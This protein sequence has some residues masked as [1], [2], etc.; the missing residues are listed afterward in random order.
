MMIRLIV[1]FQLGLLATFTLS[2][3]K[4]A[5]PTAKPA[6]PEQIE[7][8]IDSSEAP[9]TLVHVWATWCDPCREEFPELVKVMHEFPSMGV[10]LISADSPKEIE[11]VQTFLVD[12]NS[13]ADSLITTE[14]N[15]KF[16][17]TLS[18]NW[19]GALPATFFFRNGKCVSEWEGK[20]TF[21]HYKET[22]ENLL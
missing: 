4:P 10:V 13:P 14:L 5:P 9:L 17:E 6:S 22:I 16:I 20:K 15:Q 11:N 1:Y 7:I 12:H 8:A 18:P 2:G 3:C 19:G 21:E